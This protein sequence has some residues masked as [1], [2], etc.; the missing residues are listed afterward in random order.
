MSTQP[1][2]DDNAQVRLLMA[3]VG[4]TQY[5]TDE[6]IGQYVAMNMGNVRLAAADALDAIAVSEVLVSKVITTQDLQTDGAKVADALRKQADRLRAQVSAF[7]QDDI[8]DV[9]PASPRRRPEGTERP[10]EAW[11]L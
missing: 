4:D 2:P 11:G 9:I 6:Q 5:L 3:D 8:F 7:D 1:I 10:Y